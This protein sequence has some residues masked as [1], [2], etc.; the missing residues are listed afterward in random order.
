MRWPQLESEAR[1]H[2]AAAILPRHGITAATADIELR[3][4]L[5]GLLRGAPT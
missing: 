5:E 3:A 2:L 4:Q 1:Q